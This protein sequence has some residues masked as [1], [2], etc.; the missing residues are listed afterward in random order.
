M[1]LE[2]WLGRP[3]NGTFDVYTAKALQAFLNTEQRGSLRIDGNFNG[4][5]VKALQRYLGTP[6]TG[7]YS[8]SGSTMVKAM[9]RR[10]AA[11]GHL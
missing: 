8:K 2:E 10:L 1:A 11:Y 6:V 5:S 3:V 9:Q 7:G 4:E